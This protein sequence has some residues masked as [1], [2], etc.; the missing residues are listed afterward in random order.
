MLTSPRSANE[1]SSEH[2]RS[3]TTNGVIKHK[4]RA[5]RVNPVQGPLR[6]EPEVSD[7]LTTRMSAGRNAGAARAKDQT[8][9]AAEL[10]RED[11]ANLGVADRH[12]HVA[13]LR[14]LPTTQIRRPRRVRV[15]ADTLCVPVATEAS[16]CKRGRSR[17]SGDSCR[18]SR[19]QPAADFPAL[20]N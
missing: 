7:L 17:P 3:D 11:G 20:T 10:V 12:D 9:A 5:Q 6:A 8:V 4:P 14:E 1:L 13:V 2:D 18:A 19:N 16:G 15:T